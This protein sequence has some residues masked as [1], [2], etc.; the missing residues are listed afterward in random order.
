[1]YDL[2][3]PEHGCN[4][5]WETLRQCCIAMMRLVKESETSRKEDK[6]R[7]QLM[8][9]L[10]DFLDLR[11][12][13]VTPGKQ[14]TGDEPCPIPIRVA[15]DI[16]RGVITVNGQDYPAEPHHCRWV[17]ELLHAEGDYVSGEILRGLPACAGKKVSREMTNLKAKVP[18]LADR[19]KGEKGKGYRLV[20]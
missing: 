15:A 6:N 11:D 18:P 9:L 2:L 20:L 17:E 12:Y 13:D 5:A 7:T 8:E 10:R 4:E 3:K 16:R 19:I 14:N 1:L